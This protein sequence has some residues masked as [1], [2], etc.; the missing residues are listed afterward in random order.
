MRMYKE[1]EKQW[2]A[3]LA[4]EAAGADLASAKAAKKRKKH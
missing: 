4:L 3:E 1:V 2:E